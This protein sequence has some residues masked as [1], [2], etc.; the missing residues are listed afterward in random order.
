MKKILILTE[1]NIPRGQAPYVFDISSAKQRKAVIFHIVHQYRHCFSNIIPDANKASINRAKLQ[2][3]TPKILALLPSDVRYTVE[4][5]KSVL[6]DKE[7]GARKKLTLMGWHDQALRGN[8]SFAYKLIRYFGSCHRCGFHIQV[9]KVG[10]L[11]A[12]TGAA[13]RIFPSRKTARSAGRRCG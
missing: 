6:D 3:L 12:Q 2:R 7:Y 11:P 4:N 10:E 5:R 9:Y 13:V 8:V 1:R